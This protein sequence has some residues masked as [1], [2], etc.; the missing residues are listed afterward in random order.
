MDLTD[1]FGTIP[2]LSV[3]KTPFG[4]GDHL[5]DIVRDLYSN[6]RTCFL[7]MDGLS[8]AMDLKGGVLQG[9]PLSGL[10][11]NICLDPVLRPTASCDITVLACAD[12]V[13]IT[14]ESA[15]ALLKAL[16][17]SLSGGEPE[18]MRNAS[19]FWKGSGGVTP[20]FFFQ[21]MALRFP[22]SRMMKP[23]SSLAS[24]L[25]S[26]RSSSVRF[27][28]D[29]FSKFAGRVLSSKLAPRQRIDAAK[30]F[31]FSA[32]A[33]AM[34]TAAYQ[35]HW[36]RID[37]EVRAL[38]KNTLS[39][40][41]RAANEY[42]YGSSSS[43]AC[44]ISCAADDANA[45]LIDTAF[46]LLC[47]RDPL[48]RDLAREELD[49]VTRAHICD[50]P[51][52]GALASFL[53]GDCDGAFKKTSNQYSSQWSEARAASSR[54]KVSWEFSGGD[55][56]LVIGSNKLPYKK[57]RSIMKNL[58]AFCRS[59]HEARL[60]DHRSQGKVFEYVA[61]S[62]ASSHFMRTGDPFKDWRFVHKA[63]LNL[64]CLNTCKLWLHENNRNCRRCGDG[65]LETA[66]CPA[67]LP[68]QS[69]R[70]V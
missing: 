20:Q 5:V 27:D 70:A 28:I 48:V 1:A 38:I 39:L 29:R 63:R 59:N 37:R 51:D 56:S 42:I 30:S 13:T 15:A 12:D 11:F 10:L 14:V 46:K 34:H 32:F 40:P 22:L 58:R 41:P 2:H 26:F 54:L 23:T 21:L 31:V 17:L 52:D 64:L 25:A 60:A 19:S 9:D 35:K 67:K 66:S 65:H 45:S 36:N 57:R 24:P 62:P 68:G 49:D 6:A 43:G 47:S 55:P 53:R 18:E 4:S 8:D 69:A 50:Q 3:L 7:S 44:G 61:A 16:N 33:Y